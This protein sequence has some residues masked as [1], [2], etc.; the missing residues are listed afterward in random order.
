[1]SDYSDYLDKV[2]KGEISRKEF[3]RDVHRANAHNEHPIGARLAPQGLFDNECVLSYYKAR[4]EPPPMPKMKVGTI[5]R[6][7]IFQLVEVGE[8]F[9]PKPTNYP[10]RAPWLYRLVNRGLVETFEQTVEYELGVGAKL[11]DAEL[12][13][14]RPQPLGTAPYY[15]SDLKPTPKLLELIRAWKRSV[16]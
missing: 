4:G 7:T 10:D 3:M 6:R 14:L 11:T 13:Q 5:T 1:M 8:F 2:G 9:E 12:D 15:D 16:D